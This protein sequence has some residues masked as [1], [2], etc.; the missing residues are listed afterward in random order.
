MVMTNEERLVCKHC[1]KI[2]RYERPHFCPYCGKEIDPTDGLDLMNGDLE[3]YK[4]TGIAPFL[5]KGLMLWLVLLLPVSL[6]FGKA[7]VTWFSGVY[8]IATLILILFSVFVGKPGEKK[9]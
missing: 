4:W 7:G 5:M 3:I 8:A 9:S 6:I 1:E 2:I